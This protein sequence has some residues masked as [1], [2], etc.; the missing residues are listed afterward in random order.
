[1]VVLNAVDRKTIQGY[2]GSYNHHSRSQKYPSNAPLPALPTFATE[3]ALIPS[4]GDEL[5]RTRLDRPAIDIPL[6]M[7]KD[8]KKLP[9]DTE[10]CSIVI[11]AS[12]VTPLVTFTVYAIVTLD[13]N[14]RLRPTTLTPVTA[15]AGTPNCSDTVATIACEKGALEACA[16]VTPVT[17]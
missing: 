12:G 7:D 4:V 3:E 1:M 2:C 11:R 5:I 6:L 10:V 8:S 16:K 14:I 13:S 9:L 17:V 15:L